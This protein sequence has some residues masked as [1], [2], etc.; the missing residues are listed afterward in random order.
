MKQAGAP[1]V[2]VD[3]E[4][5]E[6]DPHRKLVQ[7]W[8]ARFSPQSEAEGFT[9]LTYE[10]EPGP[11]GV[12]RLTVIHELDG[13]PIAAA[14]VSGQIPGAGGGWSFVLSDLKALLETGSRM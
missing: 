3:G 11:E 14:Q 4:V 8:R 9:K 13:A 2:I 12:C 1:K 7:T 6:L 5:L 10:I